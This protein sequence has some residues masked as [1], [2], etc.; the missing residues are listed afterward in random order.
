MSLLAAAAAAAAAAVVLEFG[1]GVVDANLVREVLH[2]VR[3]V[4][5]A[6]V[7]AD[8]VAGVGFLGGGLV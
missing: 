4:Y 5:G 8:G 2:F 7:K 1:V 6:P 3:F